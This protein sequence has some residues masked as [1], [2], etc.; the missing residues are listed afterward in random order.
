MLCFPTKDEAGDVTNNGDRV[1]IICCIFTH[2]TGVQIKFAM[3]NTGY[4]VSEGG[5]AQLWVRAE[6][7]I[8][9]AISTS[10]IGQTSSALEE[11]YARTSPNLN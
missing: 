8:N 3:L 2:G 1:T 5:M 4:T 9:N 10:A 7:N 6:E 11:P